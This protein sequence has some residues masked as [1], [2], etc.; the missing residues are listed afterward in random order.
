MKKL[1][2]RL[3]RE[4]LEK[5]CQE[6]SLN[7]EVIDYVNEFESDEQLLRN[8]GLPTDILDRLAFGFSNDDITQISP[9]Q[10][11]VK[12]KDDLENVKWEVNKNRI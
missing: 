3:L 1:I 9:K 4:N 10:L 8:G 5:P 7:K 6:I 2:K 12:W 11:K